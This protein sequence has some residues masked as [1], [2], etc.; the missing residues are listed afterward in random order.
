MAQ[1]QLSRF[2]P[3]DRFPRLADHIG[4]RISGQ[5]PSWAECLP[6]IVVSHS[7]SDDL[8][9]GLDQAG[10]ELPL[11][12]VG[13][14]CYGHGA[15]HPYFGIHRGGFF[16]D[17]ENHT[18]VYHATPGRVLKDGQAADYF[19]LDYLRSRPI[20]YSFWMLTERLVE[21]A[22]KEIHRRWEE[23]RYTESDPNDFDCASFVTDIAR[24]VGSIANCDPN[25]PFT[26]TIPSNTILR[27]RPEDRGMRAILRN[28]THPPC[29][30]LFILPPEDFARLSRDSHRNDKGDWI[31]DNDHDVFNVT[32]Q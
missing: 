2:F 21:E 6:D 4:A 16:P 19:R 3:R 1:R 8:R 18:Y 11:A 22:A 28:A 20:L 7:E 13:E 9:E 5:F 12:V 25:A 31:I 26:I 17:E 15:G 10:R 30:L 24:H 32:S 27:G 14:I 23:H 29:T